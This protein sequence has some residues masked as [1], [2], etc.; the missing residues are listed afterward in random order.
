MQTTAADPIENEQIT[1]NWNPQ[2]ASK[3]SYEPKS[4]RGESSEYAQHQSSH[5]GYGQKRKRN[6]TRANDDGS[7]NK[8]SGK[9]L[10]MWTQEEENGDVKDSNFWSKVLFNNN[11]KDQRR[12]NQ[13]FPSTNSTAVIFNSIISNLKDHHPN[14]LDINDVDV[15]DRN[16]NMSDA[17]EQS[18]GNGNMNML[19]SSSTAS[20]S[21]SNHASNASKPKNLLQK[22]K[23]MKNRS[24]QSDEIAHGGAT[25][26]EHHRQS[27]NNDLS[28]ANSTFLRALNDLHL[29]YNDLSATNAGTNQ[30]EHGETMAQLTSKE[31]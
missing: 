27:L 19:A 23:L 6:N 4:N 31:R 14:N 9:T 10:S 30:R 17:A 22:H 18:N 21:D 8:S 2:I 12:S 26:G 25:G 15:I 3:Y 13:L 7:D 24:D 20:S 16:F 28:V 5:N 11:N 1:W 29:D